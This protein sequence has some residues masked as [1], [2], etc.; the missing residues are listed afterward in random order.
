[1]NHELR[2]YRQGEC[3]QAQGLRNP[4]RFSVAL[5]RTTSRACSWRWSAVSRACRLDP[6]DPQQYGYSRF[7]AA[8]A[9]S[10][11]LEQVQVLA[12]AG[13]PKLWDYAVDIFQDNHGP[14]AP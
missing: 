9:S 14:F 10:F 8:N 6:S 5:R 13:G 7:W 12:D 1:M 3:A 4:Q 2:Q 11:H